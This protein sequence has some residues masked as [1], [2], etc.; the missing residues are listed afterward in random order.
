MREKG[1]GSAGNG[2]IA[3][4]RASPCFWSRVKLVSLKWNER[5]VLARPTTVTLHLC[6]CPCFWSR[7][8]LASQCHE[9]IFWLKWNERERCRL[10]RKWLHCTCSRLSMFLIESKTRVV[11][12][13]W[14]RGVGSADHGYIAFVRAF[15]YFWSR[16][17]LVSY[18]HELILWLKWNQRERRRLGRQRLHCTCSRLSM[19]LI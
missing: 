11:K 10:G 13:K 7:V 3:F 6:A 15:P 9:L 19:F 12:M 18:W 1:V 8:N 16:V 4:A 17:K 5:D 2:Y 14:E